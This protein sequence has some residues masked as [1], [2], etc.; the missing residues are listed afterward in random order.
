MLQGVAAIDHHG[1][2]DEYEGEESIEAKGLAEEKDSQDQ[3][4]SR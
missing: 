1:D 2:P 3:L 4:P